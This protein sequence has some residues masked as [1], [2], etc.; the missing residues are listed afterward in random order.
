MRVLYVTASRSLSPTGQE[1]SVLIWVKTFRGI[2]SLGRQNLPQ[3]G[4]PRVLTQLATASAL[5]GQTEGRYLKSWYPF[6]VPCPFALRVM[7][8]IPPAIN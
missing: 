4:I 3:S 5:R 1:L 6:P 7:N 2:S 8:Q